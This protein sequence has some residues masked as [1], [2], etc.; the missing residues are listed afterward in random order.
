MSPSPPNKNKPFF[1]VLS[2]AFGLGLA[3]AVALCVVWRYHPDVFTAQARVAAIVICPP[4]LLAA[5]LEATADSTLALI[6][7]VGT[8]IFS[9][10]FL[11]AGLASF[12]YFLMTVFLRKQP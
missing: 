3:V 12:V 1:T 6:I 4:F 11:Y 7:T 9:N 10:G 2:L 8:I 5:I